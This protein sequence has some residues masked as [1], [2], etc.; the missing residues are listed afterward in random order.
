MGENKLSHADFVRK[1]ANKTQIAQKYVK[2]VLAAT[3]ELMRQELQAGRKVNLNNFGI[4]K[5]TVRAARTYKAPFAPGMKPVKKPART[6]INFKP[7][8][9]FKRDLNS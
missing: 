7:A 3:T 1:V 4:F 9:D 5:T 6:G 2:E 8:Q